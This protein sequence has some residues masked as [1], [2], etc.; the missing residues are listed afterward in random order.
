MCKDCFVMQWLIPL[1][2]F[3]TAK[4]DSVAVAPTKQRKKK[5]YALHECGAKILATN[6]EATNVKG[7]LNPNKD[8]YMINPCKVKQW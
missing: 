7:V 1:F 2:I 4:V 5:N 3:I 8:D 6:P